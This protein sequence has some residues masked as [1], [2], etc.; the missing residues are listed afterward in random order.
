MSV[1]EFHSIEIFNDVSLCE[2]KI[3][4]YKGSLPRINRVHMQITSLNKR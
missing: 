1:V 2:M 3:S 4:L